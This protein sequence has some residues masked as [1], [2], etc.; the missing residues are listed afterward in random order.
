MT[1]EPHES[2]ELGKFDD[3][4]SSTNT[5]GWKDE[6]ADGT[7]PHH[8]PSG[9]L[10]VGRAGVEPATNRLKAGITQ[11]GFSFVHHALGVCAL[12]DILSRYDHQLPQRTTSAVEISDK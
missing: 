3:Q 9:C 6:I 5:A 12:S 1:P 7:F 11:R 2:G 10:M 4:L 8:T